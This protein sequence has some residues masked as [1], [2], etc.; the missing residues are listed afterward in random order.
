[1]RVKKA[2]FNLSNSSCSHVANRSR[3]AS[4]SSVVRPRACAHSRHS[5]S[6]CPSTIVVRR[7]SSLPTVTSLALRS[8][9]VR[10]LLSC[11]SACASNR[12]TIAVM[13]ASLLGESAPAP[14][15]SAPGG[16]AAGGSAAG[17]PP[18]AGGDPRA[19]SSASSAF[20]TACTSSTSFLYLAASANSS[21]GLLGCAVFGARGLCSAVSA[22][23]LKLS[24]LACASF[25]LI[26][27]S[28][29]SKPRWNRSMKA[30]GGSTQ[31]LGTAG[32]GL[33]SGS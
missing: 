16:S 9:L 6:T 18:A 21:S 10:T 19:A 2:P 28:R 1:M 22:R 8:S 12:L 31:T 30:G 20:T 4:P 26:S 23:A 24:R 17:S 27:A 7:S 32:R 14:G 25:N 3:M 11:C 29:S 33:S 5:C 15:E 13:I